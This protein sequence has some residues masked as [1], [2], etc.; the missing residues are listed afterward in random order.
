VTVESED[1]KQIQ[2]DHGSGRAQTTPRLRDAA[3]AVKESAD[4]IRARSLD[5]I[6]TLEDELRGLAMQLDAQRALCVSMQERQRDLEARL[7]NAESTTSTTTATAELKISDSAAMLELEVSRA[8]AGDLLSRAAIDF[9]S[10][11]LKRL[12]DV[13]HAWLDASHGPAF[14][15]L[16]SDGS[17]AEDHRFSLQDLDQDKLLDGAASGQISR[18]AA[19]LEIARLRS[20]RD[21]I[22]AE[23]VRLESAEREL[24]ALKKRLARTLW[25]RMRMTLARLLK[26]KR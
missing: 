5:I 20:D 14:S 3:P 22:D 13:L 1:I 21:R 23:L 8:I 19:E 4:D 10:D 9:E 24:L 6:R 26:R 7:A 15:R 25:L 11:R 17:G 2:A 12:S 18:K 16:A